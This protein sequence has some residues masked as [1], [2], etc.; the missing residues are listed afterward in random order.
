MLNLVG[1]GQVNAQDAEAEE[2]VVD[3]IGMPEIADN[4]AAAAVEEEMARD[5]E[6]RERERGRLATACEVD[7]K[8]EAWVWS[9]VN[10]A[11]EETDS[12]LEGNK[13]GEVSVGK[14][15]CTSAENRQVELLRLSRDFNI[16]CFLAA[17]ARCYSRCVCACSG[18]NERLACL[19]WS[20]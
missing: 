14:D 9:L 15:V 13:A 16:A 19:H 2:G 12:G 17:E 8:E 3:I 4:T 6:T 18:L 5:A 7:P 11:L 10:E 20:Q 1:S